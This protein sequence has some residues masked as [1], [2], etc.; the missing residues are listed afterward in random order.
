MKPQPP[1]NVRLVA[2]DGRILPLETVYTGVDEDGLRRWIA[3]VTPDIGDVAGW[4]L[5]ADVLPARTSVGILLVERGGSAVVSEKKPVVTVVERTPEGTQIR[6]HHTLDD[7]VHMR[8]V[9]VATAGGVSLGAGRHL[10]DA[11]PEWLA[12]AQAAHRTLRD[13]AD[14]SH[15]ATH[16]SRFPGGGGPLTAVDDR[17]ATH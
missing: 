16:R 10:A 17:V 7:A 1:E 14:V 15:L 12:A 4:A 8:P 6:W 11:P 3:T 5:Q 2:P 9:L 13:G